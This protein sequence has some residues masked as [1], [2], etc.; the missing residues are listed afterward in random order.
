M[1]KF[2]GNGEVII[3][4]PKSI[5]TILIILGVI[6]GAITFTVGQNFMVKDHEKRIQGVEDCCDDM[7]NDFVPRQEIH[8]NNLLVGEQ[9]NRIEQKIDLIKG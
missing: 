2:N 4:K 7:S 8:V 3:F 5:L 6:F 9:L 1:I